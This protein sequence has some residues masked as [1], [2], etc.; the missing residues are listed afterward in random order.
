MYFPE[1][2][3]Y[4]GNAVV[5]KWKPTYNYFQYSGNLQWELTEGEYYFY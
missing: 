5:N 4:A 2:H 1:I 3:H